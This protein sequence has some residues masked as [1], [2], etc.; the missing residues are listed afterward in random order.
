MQGT[1]NVRDR[2]TMGRIE[3]F[4]LLLLLPFFSFPRF[5]TFA[6]YGERDDYNGVLLEEAK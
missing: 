5:G 1:E 2:P 4:A 3:I 6:L